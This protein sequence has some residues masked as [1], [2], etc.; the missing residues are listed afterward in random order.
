MLNAQQQ[1]K[2]GCVIAALGNQLR[3]ISMV[4]IVAHL[5]SSSSSPPMTSSIVS[6]ISSSFRSIISVCGG[7]VREGR[8]G[9]REE[10]VRREGEGGRGRE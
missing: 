8:E 7:G 4:P 5:S 6:L 2:A 1:R 10:G 9:G 3:I